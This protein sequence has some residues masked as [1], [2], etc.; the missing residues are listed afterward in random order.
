M[1]LHSSQKCAAGVD[2]SAWPASVVQEVPAH[3]VGRLGSASCPVFRHANEDAVTDGML[4]GSNILQ[5]MSD[6]HQLQEKY[7]LDSIREALL[8]EKEV[9]LQY[10]AA[11]QA[12]YSIC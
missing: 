4:E 3:D 10:I 2:V 7:E 6:M 8:R 11:P 1:G 5:H 9:F 12:E